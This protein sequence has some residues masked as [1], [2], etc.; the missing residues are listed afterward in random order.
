MF[1]KLVESDLIGADLKPRR[2]IFVASFALVA[3]LFATAV[4]AGIYAADYTLGTDSFDIAEMLAPVTASEPKTEP[5]PERTQTRDRQISQS[6]QPTRQ[7]NMARVDEPTIAPTS[8][9]VERNQYL[10]RP[11]GTFLIRKGAEGNGV[12]DYGDDRPIGDGSSSSSRAVGDDPTEADT[13][14][15]PPAPPRIEKKRPPISGGVMTG[16]ATS[17]PKPVYSAAAQA[18]GASGTVTVQ[19]TVDEEGRVMSAKALDGNVLLR[20]A[21]VD[22]ALKAK[23]N[24]TK[25]SGVPVKVT[26][27]ITYNFSR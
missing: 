7:T 18:V 26:G 22:A 9:S 16:K 4:V 13:K 20:P 1:D 14:T 24:P 11:V 27:L 2:R 23:F 6:D 15:P 3:L 19:I 12:P 8:V 10:S 17:L 25:L 21:A 5:V